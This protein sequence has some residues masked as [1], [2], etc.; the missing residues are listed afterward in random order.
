MKKILPFLFVLAVASSALAAPKPRITSPTTDCGT[1][2]IPYSY[3]ITADQVIPSGGW[4]ATPLPAGLSVNATG[5]ISGTPTVVG[6]FSITLSATNGNGTGTGPLTLTINAVPTISSL[7]PTCAAVG[8]PQFTLTVNGTNFVS[9]STVKWNATALTTTFVSSTRLTAIVPASLITAAGTAS[10]TVVSCG[11]T[12]NTQTFTIAA[13]PVITSPLT[14]CGTV[15]VLFTYTII[16][17]NN[18]TSFSASPLP[19]GLSINTSTGVISGTPTS[20]G[21]TNVTITAS[22][23]ATPCNTATATLVITIGNPPVITSPLTACGTVGTVFS[24]TITAT[25]NPTSLSASPL[26]PGLTINTSTGVISGT[27][28]TG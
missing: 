20:T 23:G 21:T 13:T 16:A 22:N 26:P 25:N 11:A 8:G 17:T 1:I 6:T 14:A 10:I 15:G 27:P 7:S 12:S 28:P 5:L 24:Y 9:G 2:G 19:A 18:P 3:Q 4:G